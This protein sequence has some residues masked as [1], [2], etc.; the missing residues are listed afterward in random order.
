MSESPELNFAESDGAPI[1]VWDWPGDG[2][3]L[4]F[5][6][7]T[8]FHGRCWDAIARDFPG[9]RRLALEFR[10]H[11]RSGKPEPPYHWR[12]FGRDVTAVARHFE[13]RGAVGIGHSMGGHALASSEAARDGAFA[14]L[15]LI[16]PV[17]FP[18]GNYGVPH[19]PVDFIR[20]R[21][22]QWSGP[23]EMLTAYRGRRPFDSWNPQVFHD[24]CGF[25]LLPHGAGFTLA[26]PPEVEASI[27]D[28]SYAPESSIYADLAQVKI[29]VTVLRADGQPE[30]GIFD[31]ASSPT[32]P[33]LAGMLPRGRDV[34]LAGRNHYIPM[35]TPELIAE[36]LR[37][38]L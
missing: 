18:P 29:P 26:C 8:G 28:A 2:P 11:G 14:A 10:G 37:S 1:A 31:L 19:P 36:V 21:R 7:A 32:W 17:I 4:V 25:A 34:L 9:R 16:D 22:A 20:R 3:P 24:Y 23:D 12:W 38:E 33:G 35:E 27:Y 6:H 5:A 30:P 15:L 13:L